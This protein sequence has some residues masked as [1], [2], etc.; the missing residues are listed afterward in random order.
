MPELPEVETVVRDLHPLLVGRRIEGVRVSR[1][2]LRKPWVR[3]WGRRLTGRRVEAVRRRG[4]W[5]VAELDDGAR[6]VFHLGMTGQLTVAPADRADPGS[7]ASEIRPGRR[8][9]AALPRRAP[10]RQCHLV[11]G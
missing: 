1:L 7:H 5:I 10:I 6:L 8:G 3:G 4:K 9:P 11:F 2:A